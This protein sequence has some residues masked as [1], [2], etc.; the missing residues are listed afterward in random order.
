M[1]ILRDYLGLKKY[2]AH[3]LTA[4]ISTVLNDT[5]LVLVK[6][7]LLTKDKIQENTDNYL[8]LR[9]MHLL[10]STHLNNTINTFYSFLEKTNLED[11][12]VESTH[13]ISNKDI[14]NYNQFGEEVIHVQNI[15]YKSSIIKSTLEI[16]AFSTFYSKHLEDSFSFMDKNAPELDKFKLISEQELWA[17]KNK[18][19]NY[20]L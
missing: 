1:T 16:T 13:F 4:L 7:F 20:I 17:D 18:H 8:K 6:Q 2:I 14:I 10:L 5:Y 12:S 15:D 19:T 11:T 3:N 9:E